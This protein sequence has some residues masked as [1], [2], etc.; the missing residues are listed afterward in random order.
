MTFD[1]I[2]D[3]LD[4]YEKLTHECEFT[5]QDCEFL[6]NFELYLTIA[7]RKDLPDS[8]SYLGKLLCIMNGDDVIKLQIK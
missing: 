1:N 7:I 5:D 4:R 8:N 3:T 6:E 2:K